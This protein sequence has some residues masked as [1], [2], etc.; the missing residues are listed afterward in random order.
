MRARGARQPQLGVLLRRLAVRDDVIRR[1]LGQRREVRGP[2]RHVTFAR[3]RCCGRSH[4]RSVI[5]AR[6]AATASQTS[7]K[8]R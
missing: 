8:R 6:S 3:A 2:H 5:T 1:G 7:A 4:S